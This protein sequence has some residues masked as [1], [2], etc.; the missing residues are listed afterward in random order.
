MALST[1]RTFLKDLIHDELDVPVM[2]ANQNVPK[3]A[4]P[5]ATLR[6]YGSRERA[7]AEL[8]APVIADGA[9]QVVTPTEAILEVQLFGKKGSFP[10]DELE[11]LV[12]RLSVDSVMN[13]CLSAGVAFYNTEAVQDISGLLDDKQTFEQRA[14]VDFR[15]RYMKS[16]D[17]DS[18][19]IEQVEISGTYLDTADE[20]PKTFIVNGG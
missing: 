11:K 9:R 10:Y 16:L 17:D 14:V 2:W 6:L 13:R 4:L 8:R 12:G 15:I 18:T 19:D 5:F 20:T 7:Q 1:L 3:L